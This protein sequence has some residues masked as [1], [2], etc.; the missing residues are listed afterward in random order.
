MHI[1][2]KGGTKAGRKR[3]KL[4]PAGPWIC[5]CNEGGEAFGR[6]RPGYLARCPDCGARR[7]SK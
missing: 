5:E 4:P 6:L 7:P 1:S 2:V 3:P